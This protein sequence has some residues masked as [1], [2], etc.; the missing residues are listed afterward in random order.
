[1]RRSRVWFDVP[2]PR[3]GRYFSLLA[4]MARRAGLEVF[5]TAR[6]HAE[7]L[8]ILD[9]VG[10]R[11]VPVGRHGGRSKMGKLIAYV[12]RALELA[13][14]ISEERP[15]VLVSLASPEA[16]RVAFGLGI[17]SITL[18]DAPHAVHVARLTFPLSS[19]VVYPAAIPAHL[20]IDMGASP[21]SLRP[22]EGVDPVAWMKRARPDPSPL[23][24]MGLDLGSDL[25][26]VRPEERKAAYLADLDLEGSVT[27]SV[28]EEALSL[29]AKVILVPRYPDQ[30]RFFAERFGGRVL[31]PERPFDAV[32]SYFFFSLVVS[33]GSSMAIEASL[34]GTPAISVFPLDAPLYDVE[35]VSRAG[36]PIWRIRD[37]GEAAELTA[38][39]LED[40]ERYRLTD[41]REML[42]RLEDPSEV[43]MSEILSLLD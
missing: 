4:E 31:I 11:Y 25:V 12:E 36:F 8:K 21:A 28:V 42:S 7:T 13:R 1:M 15:D 29:G 38:Q 41:Y 23:L 43:I 10:E 2:S 26:L 35:F 24:E 34:V 37:P 16:V 30:R 6:D 14:L 27:V 33:G 18:F 39:V 17:P 19:R 32:S 3:E 9:M 40:P 22:F 5:M 20:L